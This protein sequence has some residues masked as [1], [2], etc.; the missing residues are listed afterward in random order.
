M[1]MRFSA[2]R[3]KLIA[4]SFKSIGIL[5]FALTIF[6]S[7]DTKQA[8]VPIKGTWQLFSATLIDKGDTTTTDYTIDKKFIK[9]IN[10]SHF[11]F[12]SHD[13]NKGKDSLATFSAGAGTYKLVDSSYTE[14]LEFCSSR[15]WE[16]NDFHFTVSIR[17]DTLIQT[18]IE[19]VVSAGIDRLNIEKYVRVK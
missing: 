18:G 11:S 12:I 14:H 16:N 17:N 13:L 8:A 7:C 4:H 10:D 19:K 15:E 9:I 3:P 6:Y 1:K 2:H 5:L